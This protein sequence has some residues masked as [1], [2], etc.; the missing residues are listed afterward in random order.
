MIVLHF[1]ASEATIHSNNAVYIL[2]NISVKNTK[3]KKY[4]KDAVIVKC[5]FPV[6][7]L[8]KLTL[9]GCRLQYLVTC[10]NLYSSHC[11]GVILLSRLHNLPAGNFQ[12]I[13]L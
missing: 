7:F 12:E 13:M 9:R 11:S 4:R 2:N 1:N 5:F 3:W 8:L 6:L 10:I